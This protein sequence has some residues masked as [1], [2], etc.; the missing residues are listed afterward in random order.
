[1][2]LVFCTTLALCGA[3]LA[4]AYMI[5]YVHAAGEREQKVRVAIVGEEQ[6]SYLGIGIGL[7]QNL[8]SSR[9]NIDFV[10]M[11][12][13]AAKEALSRGE[14]VGYLLVDDEFIEG[15]GRGENIPLLYVTNAVGTG[16]TD[17]LMR[18]VSDLISVTIIHAEK[19]IYAMQD[20][21]LE[22][23]PAERLAEATDKMNLRMI[24]AVVKR[25]NLYETRIYDVYQKTPVAVYYASGL[26]VFFFAGLGWKCRSDTG[27]EGSAAA[28]AAGSKG[29]FGALADC[30]RIPFSLC[31]FTAAVRN[32]A[33]SCLD[34]GDLFFYGYVEPGL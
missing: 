28:S 29:L 22:Q 7:I 25:S 19:A 27:Q 9:F 2:P 5:F 20:Y 14:I 34:C 4:L 21:V 16:L 32:G 3:L 6:N 23:G 8:D 24:S 30:G 10:S 13:E 12:E 26:L 15:L 17:A 18:E 1:M 33:G 11:E 31:D